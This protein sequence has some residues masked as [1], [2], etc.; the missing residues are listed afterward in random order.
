[1]RSVCSAMKPQL[2]YLF[3]A[4]LKLIERERRPRAP[5]RANTTAKQ[6][7][8]TVSSTVVTPPLAMYHHHCLIVGQSSSSGLAAPGLLY[9]QS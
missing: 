5:N 3:Q 9:A 8:M 6:M 7:E 1:M 4:S 2:R